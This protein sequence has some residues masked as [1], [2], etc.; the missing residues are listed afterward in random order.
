MQYVF[1]WQKFILF[2]G[3]FARLFRPSFMVFFLSRL[4]FFKLH[5]DLFL[6]V[7]PSG[8]HRI[9]VIINHNRESTHSFHSFKKSVH[10]NN[11]HYRTSNKIER[12]H[13]KYR[14]I[15]EN[16]ESKKEKGS[17]QNNTQTTLV[18]IC[19]HGQCKIHF[20]RKKDN[21]IY[22]FLSFPQNE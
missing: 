12:L 20:P 7:Q 22:F 13:G 8:H 9:L 21:N 11:G 6:Y 5:C 2:W 3:V 19:K 1:P 17:F 16:S 15:P 18:R 4:F 10:A 14:M